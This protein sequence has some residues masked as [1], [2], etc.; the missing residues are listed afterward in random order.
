MNELL[1]IPALFVIGLVIGTFLEKRHYKS[2][3]EREEKLRSIVTVSSK[4]IPDLPYTPQITLVRG[5]V[6]ISTDYFKRLLAALRMIVGGRVSAFENLIDRSRREAMLRMKEEARALGAEMIFNIRMETSSVFMDSGTGT[7]S[8][9]VL[10]YGTALIQP[11]RKNQPAI[12][13]G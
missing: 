3:Y 6:V 5:S 9:E 1:F 12:T 8:V 13:G 7:G 10:V 11:Q 2:I 4:H